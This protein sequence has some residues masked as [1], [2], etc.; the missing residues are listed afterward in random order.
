MNTE[1]IVNVRPITP[2]AL[3]SGIDV[4][5]RQRAALER[6]DAEDFSMVIYLTRKHHRAIG[7]V[8]DAAYYEDGCAALKMYYA[9][10]IF[11]PSNLHAI[12]G[13]LDPFWHAHI[14]D[15]VAYE[16]LARDVGLFMHHDPLNSENTAKVAAVSEVYDYTSEA[17]AR[18]FGASNVDARF[19]PVGSENAHIVC[20][21]DTEI[22]PALAQTDIWPEQP[23]LAAHRAAYGHAARRRFLAEALAQ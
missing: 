22:A 15:T 16:K 12:S 20:V 2:F 21:H 19:F 17:L 5:P 23:A 11:D 13:A 4:S 6:L 10:A 9:T 14:L 8:H 7:Q 1:S 18:I 3:S